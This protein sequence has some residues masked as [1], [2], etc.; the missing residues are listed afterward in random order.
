MAADPVRA[1]EE[2]LAT[3]EVT[4]LPVSPHAIAEK[5]RIAVD[6]AHIDGASG[7]LMYV[8]TTFGIRYATNI[9]SSGSQRFSVAHELGHY[10]LPGHFEALL[11]SGVHRSRAGFQSD[12]SYEREA[13]LFASSL[14][15]PRKLFTAALAKNGDGIEALRRVANLCDTSLIATAIRFTQCSDEPVAMVVTSGRTID[16]CFMST[17]LKDRPGIAWTRKNEPVPTDSLTQRFNRDPA[18]VERAETR[19]GSSVLSD[20]FGGPGDIETIEE[21]I[22]LGSYGKTLTILRGIE[23]ADEEEEEEEENLRESWTP[24]FRR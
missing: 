21:V 13:D 11:G 18:R 22:G 8:G 23:F 14:L 20:W 3:H 16:Y 12:N 1:A 24:R 17:S 10:H 6:G 5:L 7:I 19:E 2:V 4:S 9:D 15:M